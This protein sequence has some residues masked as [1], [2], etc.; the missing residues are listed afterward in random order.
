MEIK[1]ILI[2]KKIEKGE[3]SLFHDIQCTKIRLLSKIINC[4]MIVIA[5]IFLIS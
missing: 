4:V 1:Y 5:A 3:A 2:E